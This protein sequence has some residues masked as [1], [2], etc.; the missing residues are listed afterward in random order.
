M[1]EQDQEQPTIRDTATV[2]VAATVDGTKKRKTRSDKGKKR[3]PRKVVTD[4]LGLDQV[5]ADVRAAAVACR[6]PGQVIRP[7]SPTEV[8]VV[9]S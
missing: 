9:N 8:L 5:R 7:I 2:T 6:K 3:G 4:T 1:T